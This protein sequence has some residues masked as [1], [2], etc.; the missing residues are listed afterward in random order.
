MF[1]TA[2][3]ITLLCLPAL[4]LLSDLSG[5]GVRGDSKTK[6]RESGAITVKAVDTG[7]KTGFKVQRGEWVELEIKGKWR[8]WDQWDYTG[9]QGHPQFKKINAIGH[10]GVL[11]LQI[12]SG[13]PFA[14]KDE[15][16]FQAADSGEISLWPNR[17]EYTNLKADGELTVVIRTGDGLKDKKARVQVSA[18]EAQDKLLADPEVK[19]ALVILNQARKTCGLNPVQLS[20]TRS[21]ACQKHS[22]YLV[23]NKD[24]PLVQ[25]LKAH[26]EFKGLK[27]YSAEGAEVGKHSV[28]H[29]VAPSQAIDDWLA[30]FY[31]RVPLLQPNLKEVGIGYY[32]QGKE[33]ACGIA[34]PANDFVEDAKDIVYYPDDGHTNVPRTF[35]DEVPSPLPS[36][37]RGPAGFPIT[38]YFA[39]DQ[40][41]KDVEVKLTGPKDAQLPCYVSTPDAPATS[42]PQWNSVCAI[43]AKPLARATAYT[44]TL[45]CTV[46]GKPHT[47]TWRFT[48][49]K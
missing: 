23:L 44:V 33:W 43:P 15:F 21:I 36:S 48:T 46:S 4:W 14:L 16:P 5:P 1:S 34:S 2:K 22:R 8:M 6:E 3:R 41:V 19:Q 12:G 25:G 45:R 29:Y 24:S 18:K 17:G 39:R 35:G 42:F 11:V 13:K 37:H 7:V 31:H 26:E 47:R 38:I 27:G 30:S 28:I 40:K 49:G 9:A 20:V 32:R 10:L